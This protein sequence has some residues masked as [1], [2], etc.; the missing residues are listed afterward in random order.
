[1]LRLGAEGGLRVAEIAG[2]RT[3]D[4]DGEWLTVTGKGGTI[5]TV[6]LEDELLEVLRTLEVTT[7]RWGFYFPGRVHEPVA[8]STVWRHVR[9]LTGLNTHALRHRAGTS[10]YRNTGFDLRLAQEFLG[11]AS[12]TTTA[13]YVHVDREDMSRASQA[14]R[15]RR[16]A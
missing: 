10:V 1:M 2:L 9:A 5:R 3:A 13:I 11:H 8:P 6:H 15:L 7:A 16:A 12:P 14:T 4:R